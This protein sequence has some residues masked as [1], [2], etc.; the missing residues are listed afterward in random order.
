MGSGPFDSEIPHPQVL[1][2]KECIWYPGAGGLGSHME[3]H[4]HLHPKENMHK[5]RQGSKSFHRADLPLAAVL[6]ALK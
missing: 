6:L 1:S 2:G 4:P 5:H 3:K